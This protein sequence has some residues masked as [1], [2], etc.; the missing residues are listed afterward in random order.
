LFSEK[1]LKKAEKG[2]AIEGLPKTRTGKNDNTPRKKENFQGRTSKSGLQT[3]IS[4][5]RQLKN[6]VRE[7]TLGRS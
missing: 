7:E 3:A 5:T 4:A 1:L 6:E 2:G